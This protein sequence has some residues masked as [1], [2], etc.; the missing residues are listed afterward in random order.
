MLFD[1]LGVDYVLI[2]NE[3]DGININKNAGSTHIEG[4]QKLVIENNLDCG[5]AYDGDADRCLMV[6]EFGNLVDGDKVMAIYGK[7]LLDQNKLKNNT[8]V[9]TVM[10]NLGFSKFCENNG[11][12]FVATKVG[13]RYVL[14]SMLENDYIVG[15]E[16][17]GHVIFR[18][19]ANT[20][21]GELTSIQILNVMIKTGLKLSELAKVMETYP[22]VLKNVNVSKEGKETYKENEKINDMIEKSNEKLKGEGRILVRASG[23]ENLIRV[24]LEGKNIDQ[25]TKICDEIVEVIEKELN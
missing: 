23:T 15:G 10:S 24:M 25:I 20:G 22:Q 12:N 11:I 8:L 13:D 5:I 1:S 14:E 2:N 17:S 16:Q 3:P 4:L 7:Y 21:D 6:D 18:E 9:G 19:F